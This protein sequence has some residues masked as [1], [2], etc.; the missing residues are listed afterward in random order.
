[1]TSPTTSTGKTTS[2]HETV[3]TPYEE[4]A[5]AQFCQV[6]EDVGAEFDILPQDRI[7]E[8]FQKSKK[9][10]S[11]PAI[12]S[13][14]WARF[15]RVFGTILSLE[16]ETCKDNPDRRKV[17]LQRTYAIES[18]AKRRLE[19]APQKPAILLLGK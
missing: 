13:E 7:E 4:L 5:F 14:E 2:I 16:Y 17:L 11:N 6:V 15:D 12:T 8:L 1:M 3:L 18:A 9:A 19:K 10:V